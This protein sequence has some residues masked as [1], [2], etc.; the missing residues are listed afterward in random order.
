MLA[1]R[2][3]STFTVVDTAG[4]KY[5]IQREQW[6]DANTALRKAGIGVIAIVAPDDKELD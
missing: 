4:D 3:R 1:A 5:G 2:K 6:D